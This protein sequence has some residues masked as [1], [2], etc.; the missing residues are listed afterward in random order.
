MVLRFALR[1][2]RL[3]DSTEIP[4][5][6]D[7]NSRKQKLALAMGNHIFEY[8]NPYIYIYINPCKSSITGFSTGFTL[9]LLPRGRP[10]VPSFA[11][12]KTLRPKMVP[13]RDCAHPFAWCFIAPNKLRL[14]STY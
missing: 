7:G 12:E 11:A 10:L 14:Y 9:T 13:L 3:G 6:H 5:N 1:R 2:A 8:M 4:R